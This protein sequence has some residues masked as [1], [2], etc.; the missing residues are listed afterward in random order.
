[1]SGDSRPKISIACGGTGGHLFPGVAIAQELLQR[2]CSVELIITE[3]DVDKRA[4]EGLAGLEIVA[5]PARSPAHGKV[6][7]LAGLARSHRLLSKLWKRNPPQAV[8]AMGGFC[9][10][11]PVLT[12]RGKGIPSFL[13]ESNTVPGRANRFVARFCRQV[14]LWFPEAADHIPG[15]RVSITGMPVRDSFVAGEKAGCREALGLSPDRPV[16]LVMGGS[17]GATA[18]NRAVSGGLDELSR[19]NPSL[20]YIHLTGTDDLDWVRKRYESLGLQAHV[21]AFSDEMELILSASTLVVA[22][23][24]ASS[25]AELAVTRLPSVL[26]PYPH[27]ADNHQFYNAGA[28]VASDAALMMDEAEAKSGAV[29]P[30]VS[31]LIRDTEKRAAMTRALGL[32]E[33]PKA[34]SKLVECVFADIGCLG[35]V[36]DSGVIGKGGDYPEQD[37]EARMPLASQPMAGTWERNAG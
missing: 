15:S 16:L 13:H 8:I 1:V 37:E 30:L 21:R 14:F 31:K 22:R 27:A 17:Q 12:A 20:Q 10:V 32:W 7:F 24:G 35:Q 26:V 3:K 18:I 6:G 23:S 5:I 36:T 4:V 2:G 34:A 28:F 25:L 9:S 11:P 33:S 19:E 29:V